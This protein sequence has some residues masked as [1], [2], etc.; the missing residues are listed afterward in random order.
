MDLIN[1]LAIAIGILILGTFFLGLVGFFK[2]VQALK[3]IMED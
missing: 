1:L 2:F 3:F